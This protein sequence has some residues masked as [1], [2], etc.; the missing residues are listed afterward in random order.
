MNTKNIFILLFFVSISVFSQTTLISAGDTWKYLDDGSD[1]GTSWHDSVFDDSSWASGASELGYGDGGEAT[2]VSYGPNAS[3]KYPT[4]YFR[5]TFNVTDHTLYNDLIMEAIRDDGMVV[6]LNGVKVWSDNMNTSFNYLSHSNSTVGGS[7]ESTWISKSIVSNLVTGANTIAVEIHQVNNTS[8]DISFN[9]KLNAYSFIPTEITRGPYI[10]STTVNSTIIKWRTNKVTN[11]IINFGTS[12]GSLTS[13][14]TDN[15]DT[16]E[17][18]ITLTGLLE[19]TKYFYEISDSNGIYVPKNIEMYATTAPTVGTQQFV[20]A[21]VLGDAGTGNQNQKNV[22]DQYYNYVTNVTTNPNQ[23]DMML[24][25]G[26]NAYSTGTDTNY[27][28]GLFNIYNDMLKKTTTWSCIGNHDGY[29]AST[30]SQSGPYYDI[31]TF[32]KAAEAG[33]VASGTEGYY[34]FDYANIHFIVLESNTLSSDATQ[35]AWCTADIQATTQDWIVAIFHHPPYTKGSHNSDSEGALVNMRTNFLPIL[36][37]NGVDLVLNGHSHSYERTFF[38][39]GHYGISDTFNPT[40]H[41]VGANGDL[42]GKA[43]TSDGAYTKTNV[44]T[45]GAV[46]ITT[47][48]AGKISGGLLDHEAHYAALNQLGSCVLEIESNGTSTQ[49]LT[50]K[51]LTDTGSITDYF[52]INKTGFVLSTEEEKTINEAIKIYPLPVNNILNIKIDNSEKIKT[53]TFYNMI[54]VL[55]KE[56]KGN[57]VNVSSLSSGTYILEINTSKKQYFKTLIKE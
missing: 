16:T 54:G 35:M 32:P 5:K 14:A 24:F 18:E 31:F 33:G 27:Q 51:F 46:Y 7:G 25:L 49:S 55:V 47:G 15:T 21:W 23:T 37:D 41:T 34:S 2:I 13:T 19:N 44:D 45:K 53:V 1:Q 36:E 30:S 26:D 8:S 48:S 57:Q 22:R 56:S 52:T 28:S 9:F 42:S 6:Y 10:Q 17:H 38:I 4:T 50:V 43:D 11:S 40:T 12:L 20:R 29:S 3:N 39:N